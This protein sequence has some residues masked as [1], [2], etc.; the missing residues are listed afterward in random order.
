LRLVARRSSGV[1]DA[2][3][4]EAE[5]AHPVAASG[6]CAACGVTHSLPRTPAAE[7]AAAEL[8]SRVRS[9]GR[10]DFDAPEPVCRAAV[11]LRR[12]QRAPDAQRCFTLCRM[13]AGRTLLRK[14]E[15]SER[16]APARA[17]ADAG[18]AAG[19]G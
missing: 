12:H 3:P 2:R 7:A 14:H 13:A 5:A 16:R 17:G 9:A 1:V 11:L 19:V 15:I 10:F 4:P 6:F 18:R 8:L